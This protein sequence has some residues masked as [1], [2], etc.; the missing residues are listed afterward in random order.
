MLIHTVFFW[1][2]PGLSAAQRADFRRGVESLGAI[3]SVER[4]YL[5]PPAPTPARA[6]VD[7][8]VSRGLTVIFRDAA[9]HEAYQIDPVHRAFVAQFQ[10]RWIRV[11][12]YDFETAGAPKPAP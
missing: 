4:A 11:Q 5:G 12:V 1:L 2:K 10:D 8:S 7:A 6:V 9:A 3:A